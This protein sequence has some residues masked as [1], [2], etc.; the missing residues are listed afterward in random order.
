MVTVLLWVLVVFSVAVIVVFLCGLFCDG[1]ASNKGTHRTVIR[2]YGI[3]R[4]MEAAQLK[5][6]L[7]RDAAYLRRALRRDLD[8]QGK[9]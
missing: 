3:R 9:L 6:E 1:L 4:R 2:L 5:T 7:R 8:E